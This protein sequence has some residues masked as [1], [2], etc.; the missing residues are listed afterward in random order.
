MDKKSNTLDIWK[1]LLFLI[2]F[3]RWL[4]ITLPILLGS[5]LAF[6]MTG[7]IKLYW[8]LLFLIGIF[9]IEIGT[10]SINILLNLENNADKFSF[11][12]KKDINQIKLFAIFPLLFGGLIGLYIALYY[13]PLIFWVG[14]P[15]IILGLLYYTPS[16]KENIYD[17]KEITAGIILGPL[18]VIGSFLIQTSS[19]S[20]LSLLISIPP[21]LLIAITNWLDKFVNNNKYF[22][23]NLR[24]STK[25]KNKNGNKIYIFLFSTCY[26][27]L[28]LI[29]V[30]FTSLFWL[31][32]FITLPLAIKSVKTVFNDYNS[33]KKIME[34]KTNTIKIYHLVTV[35]MIFALILEKL[36]R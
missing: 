5:S 32:P 10:K 35:M 26:T 15:A 6:N 12:S 31:L 34:I 19:F 16:F 30:V 7:N 4:I 3:K 8:L 9:S 20:A 25:F 22:K 28:A 18:T 24:P 11:R 27:T 29:F 1:I 33:N 21:G 14:I 2:S 17:L 36:F 13:E 23:D